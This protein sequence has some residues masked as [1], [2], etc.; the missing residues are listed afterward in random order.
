MEVL[1]FMIKIKKIFFFC[2]NMEFPNE[3]FL[4]NIKFVKNCE[5]ENIFLLSNQV[6]NEMYEINYL[7]DKT[8]IHKFDNPSYSSEKIL[9][10]KIKD[11]EYISYFINCPENSN[12]CY[13]Y[14]RKFQIYF[15]DNQLKIINEI[16]SDKNIN[17]ENNFICIDYSE[18]YI[19]CIFSEINESSNNN[20]LKLSF[21]DSDTFEN[22]Y[23]FNLEQKFDI[24]FFDSMISLNDNAFVISFSIE[25][26]IVKVLLKTIK[27][28]DENESPNL[29][30][31]IEDINYLNIN[32][33]GYF[34]LESEGDRDSLCRINDNKFAILLDNLNDV[35]E[36]TRGNPNILIYIFTIFNEHKNVNIRRYSINFNLYNMVNH[37]SILGYNLGQFFGILIELSDPNDKN[38]TNSGFMTFG[39]V[40]TTNSSIIFDDEFIRDNSLLS[41]SLVPGNYIGKIENNLFGYEDL[42]VIILSLPDENLGYFIKNNEEKIQINDLLNLNS[43]IKFKLNENYDP[44]FYSI[45]FAGAVKEP[46]YDKM[47]KYADQLL[48]YPEETNVDEKDFYEPQIFVGR[49]FEFRFEVKAKKEGQDDNE[50]YPSC[51]SCYSYSKDDDNHLCKICKPGY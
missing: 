2:K 12:K 7:E 36:N 4:E 33:D 47:N 25:K 19:I 8:I 42:R 27:F 46:E 18:N 41:E 44:G 35:P 17:S 22:K 1:H 13:P 15:D 30:N 48:S 32:A 49:K 40:N 3:K 37:G 51:A 5:N 21:Y 9:P 50:C 14:F 45:E 20:N 11:R 10:L 6:D 16:K 28:N 38:I 24:V 26:N 43:E 31:Y 39:Y 34:S 23:S 29:M